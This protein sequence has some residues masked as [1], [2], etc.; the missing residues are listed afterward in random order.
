VLFGT[1][2]ETGVGD[3]QGFLERLQSW[4]GERTGGELAPW[5]RALVAAVTMILAGALSALGVAELIA[6]GYGTLSWGFMLVYVLPLLTIGM[7]RIARS[8]G[9]VSG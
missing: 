3:I 9:T 8:G 1:F 6:S 5:F 2:I 4:W 7:W